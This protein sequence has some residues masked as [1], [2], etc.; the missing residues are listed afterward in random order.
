MEGL[1]GLMVG[2]GLTV[3]V[4]VV[5]PCLIRPR[6]W[7]WAQV[8]KRTSHPLAP[9][10]LLAGS[11]V[12]AGGVVACSLL[13][14]AAPSDAVAEAPTVAVTPS[15]PAAPVAEQPAASTVARRDRAAATLAA[16]DEELDILVQQA[17]QSLSQ[18]TLG[19]RPALQA[20]RG[21]AAAAAELH[22]EHE[23]HARACQLTNLY[24]DVRFLRVAE[25]VTGG[26]VSCKLS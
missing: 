5:W 13:W 21:L 9:L 10:F 19:L 7:L 2:V 20:F 6:R 12:L 16:T 26:S 17:R 14:S 23:L 18:R 24:R 15:E 4:V 22:Q 1:A 11:V 25:Q 3:L 8:T